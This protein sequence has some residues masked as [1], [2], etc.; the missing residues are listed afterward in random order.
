VKVEKAAVLASSSEIDA[1]GR[2]E[3]SLRIGADATGI[4][5]CEATPTVPTGIS[6]LVDAEG[7]P[8]AAANG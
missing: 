8:V 3:G 6:E 4:L 1:E 7:E 2:R 5:T